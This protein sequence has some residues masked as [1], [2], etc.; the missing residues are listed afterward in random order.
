MSDDLEAVLKDAGEHMRRQKERIKQLELVEK[1]F[2][3]NQQTWSRNIA[4]IEQLEAALREM[5]E[6]VATH[7][8]YVGNSPAGELACEWTMGAIKEIHAKMEG[9][10]VRQALEGKDD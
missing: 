2:E 10:I 5:L 1:A 7:R 3:Q 6:I 4:R 9:V 8:V